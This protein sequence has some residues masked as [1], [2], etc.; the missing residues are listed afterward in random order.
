MVFKC[1]WTR[2]T[3]AI[4]RIKSSQGKKSVSKVSFLRAL[5]SILLSEIPLINFVFKKCSSEFL[6]C[7]HFSSACPK[8]VFLAEKWN[9]AKNRNKRKTKFHMYK[10]EITKRKKLLRIFSGIYRNTG[11]SRK[12]LWINMPTTRTV[13]IIWHFYMY[14]KIYQIC[15]RKKLRRGSHIKIWVMIRKFTPML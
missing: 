5:H 14:L 15:H 8:K 3:W 2:K 13:P 9:N 6:T 1:S 12:T 10:K 7:E 4:A 11:I